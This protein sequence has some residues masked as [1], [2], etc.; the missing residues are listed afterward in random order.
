[1]T[2]TKKARSPKTAKQ[3]IGEGFFTLLPRHA[4]TRPI[5]KTV[6]PG[7]PSL[8]TKG[9]DHHGNPATLNKC[10]RGPREKGNSK[11]NLM[12][13]ERQQHFGNPC[14]DVPNAN[15]CPKKPPGLLAGEANQ[16]PR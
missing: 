12:E 9:A 5:I 8:K 11:G 16:R 13:L 6:R 7:L 3:G 15:E 14:G 4:N 2:V 10:G 1:M